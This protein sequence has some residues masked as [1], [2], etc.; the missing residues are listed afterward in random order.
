MAETAYVPTDACVLWPGAAAS[1]PV[2]WSRYATCDGC[3]L[4]GVSDDT[5]TS[6]GGD[7]DHTGAHTHTGDAHYHSMTSTSTDP[8]SS[9]VMKVGVGD[10]TATPG[11][12]SHYHVAA[13]SQSVVITYQNPTESLSDEAAVPPAMT[14]IIL[15]PDDASQHVPDDAVCFS[16]AASAPTGWHITDGDGGT[17]DLDDLF[18]VGADVGEDGGDSVGSATHTHTFTHTHVDDTH[19]HPSSLCGNS[20]DIVDV[21]AGATSFRKPPKH[22]NIS[23]PFGSAGTTN[24]T[25][26]TMDAASSEPAYRKLLGVQNITGSAETPLNVVLPYFG[27]VADIPTNW[28][29][30]DGT[31]GTYDLTAHQ[32]KIT[33]TGGEV[34]DTGG[35]NTHSH[36]STTP[37]NHIHG[38]S[39]GHAGAS[40][41]T[42]I[43]STTNYGTRKYWPWEH[44]HTW[45]IGT[46][47]PTLQPATFTSGSSDGRAPYRTCVF[48]QKI[49]KPG[50]ARRRMFVVS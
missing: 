40:D 32:I 25:A 39:H 45:T 9:L 33:T 7:H 48:V 14:V 31:G 8:D 11:D 42:D 24:S 46:A 10:V 35:S 43:D 20:A 15:K 16:A 44:D 34:G 50:A 29:I 13:N 49:S 17:V 5:R 1:I 3:F 27:L 28:H 37:H 30:C 47:A 6:G 38:S 36:T 4:Q 19:V 18:V 23:L 2:N 41:G 26:A 22:H 21:E 12:I